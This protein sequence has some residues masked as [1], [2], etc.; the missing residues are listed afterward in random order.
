MLELHRDFS[1]TAS[2]HRPHE[3]TVA[4]RSYLAAF[5]PIDFEANPNSYVNKEDIMTS[6][7]KLARATDEDNILRQ[8]GSLPRVQLAVCAISQ[9]SCCF[10]LLI[11]PNFPVLR[12][13]RH[14]RSLESIPHITIF[15]HHG[16]TDTEVVYILS[17]QRPSSIH[18]V[19]CAL[20]GTRSEPWQAVFD[21]AQGS[22][23]N[24]RWT[25]SLL[26]SGWYG[27]WHY[28]E[29]T[30]FVSTTCYSIRFYTPSCIRLP[31][32]YTAV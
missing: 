28:G 1:N 14:P 6:R 31:V 13:S 12:R 24:R 8:E 25:T 7:V 30:T 32:T 18:H 16:D 27:E 21:Y 15:L 23:R 19:K 22:R 11:Y 2:A 26:L 9:S 10:V 3:E 5:H 4:H 17:S 20:D 29:A